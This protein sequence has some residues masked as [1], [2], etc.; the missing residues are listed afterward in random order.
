MPSYSV[1]VLKSFM[2]N[3]VSCL[4]SQKMMDTI[5][6]V[7]LPILEQVPGSILPPGSRI[8]K[9]KSREFI[10]ISS[11]VDKYLPEKLYNGV[12]QFLALLR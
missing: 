8:P 9:S 5:L 10:F 2:A 12:S 11:E 3:Y 7:G 6:E 1:L 4:F